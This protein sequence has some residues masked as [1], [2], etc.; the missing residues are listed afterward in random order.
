MCAIQ[1]ISCN[2]FTHIVHI[3]YNVD[4]LELQCRVCH[5]YGFHKI[6]RCDYGAMFAKDD[7]VIKSPFAKYTVWSRK[8]R[9]WKPE[10]EEWMNEEIERRKNDGYKEESKRRKAEG[11]ED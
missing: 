3:T 10:Y 2:E 1:C 11:F 4:H 9:N 7:E 6:T 8:K 5:Q